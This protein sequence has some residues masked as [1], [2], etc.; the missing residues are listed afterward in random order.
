MKKLK[1]LFFLHILLMLYSMSGICS[2][3]AAGEQFMSIRFC[4]YYVMVILILGV[5]AI[6][7]QQVIK[8]LSLTTAYA[9]R[10]V[11]VIWGIIWGVL[12]FGES[13][14]VNKVIGA[15]LVFTGTILYS[16]AD[17]GTENG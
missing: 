5:Y 16:K 17:E 13:I 1:V 12:F 11:A 2:K 10:A 3:L 15:M 9:N 8:R 6:G 14:T 7:W 4:F